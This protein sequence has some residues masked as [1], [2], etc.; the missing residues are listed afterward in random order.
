MTLSLWMQ[1]I[2]P[3]TFGKTIPE[4]K[5]ILAGMEAP[6]NMGKEFRTAFREMYPRLAK[7]YDLP[8]IPF[9]LENVGGI[10]ELNQADGIH[11]TSKGH[12]IVA[13]NIWKVLQPL[14]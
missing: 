12:K 1:E 4:A 6:P 2:M 13:E 9:L 7:S 11:P 5:I 14:L 10:P 8:L 3:V